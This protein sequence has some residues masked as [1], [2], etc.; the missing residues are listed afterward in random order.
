[1]SAMGRQRPFRILAAQGP[2]SGVKR[3]FKILKIKIFKG[4][5]RPTA[6]VGFKQ[7][8]TPPKR[9]LNSKLQPIQYKEQASWLRSSIKDL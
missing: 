2:L 8:E 1:M 9:G 6:V 4:R 5:S 3:P 7:K